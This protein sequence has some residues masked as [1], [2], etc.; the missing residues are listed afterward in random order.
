MSTT[1]SHEADLYKAIAYLRDL[2]TELEERSAVRGQRVNSVARE[3]MRYQLDHARKLV[4]ALER[5]AP[6]ISDLS[7]HDGEQALIDLQKARTWCDLVEAKIMS[8][9]AD[10]S[11]RVQ[12]T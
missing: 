10:E 4:A 8:I 2:D 12:Q 7:Y 3:D 11:A 1:Q 6:N 5:H 9:C